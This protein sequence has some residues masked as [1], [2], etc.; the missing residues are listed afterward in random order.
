MH[1]EIIARA[2]EIVA[3]NTGEFS[4]CVLALIDLDGY[5][6]ASTISASKTDGIRWVTFCTGLG[7]TRTKRIDKCNHASVCFNGPDYN[8]TLVGTM[9]VIT[10]P[11]VKKEMW[12]A[13]LKSHFSGPEDPNYCV[14]RFNTQRYNLLVD[15]KEARGML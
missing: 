8:I 1:E 15:W 6:T 11:N 5:P 2:G 7:S 12:Y 10:D 9:E 14:L 4:Y 3:R 13:G